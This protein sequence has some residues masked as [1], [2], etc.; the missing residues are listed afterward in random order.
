MVRWALGHVSARRIPR[1]T[2]H[3]LILS[4]LFSPFFYI[5]LS[6]LPVCIPELWQ[7]DSGVC[8]VSAHR[9]ERNCLNRSVRG[10]DSD[11]C[12]SYPLSFLFGLCIS[13]LICVVLFPVGRVELPQRMMTGL[14]GVLMMS[15][16]QA[17]SCHSVLF[18]AIFSPFQHKMWSVQNPYT[19]FLSS[20][21]L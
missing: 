8:W 4:A 15:S 10:M 11:V 13:A 1:S 14:T 5:S 19:Y 12:C 7:D 21:W 20:R 9:P 17:Q 16:L 3:A 2:L 18:V 6:E